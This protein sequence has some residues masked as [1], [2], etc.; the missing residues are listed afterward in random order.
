MYRVQCGGI[1]WSGATC[2]TSGNTCV[3]QNDWYSQCLPGAAPV[4]TTS[5]KAS[6]TS[7][8]ST[9]KASST[10]TTSTSK[11]TSTT[12]T[13]TSKTSTTTSSPGTTTSSPGVTTTVPGGASTTASYSG[14]PFSGVQLWAND[15]YAS[16]VSSLAIPSL[17][18]AL[19]T[20]A[21]A[22]AKVPSFQWL[23]RNVTIDTLLVKTLSQI[24]AANKAGA[25]PAYAGT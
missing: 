9:S 17:S 23:D 24:R 3:Y 6:T 7:T 12:T 22:V 11:V 21:A 10:S 18:A 20:K 25:S 14:N 1:G 2:C 5:T 16:E 19:A 13:S 15:Y 8:T 4:T